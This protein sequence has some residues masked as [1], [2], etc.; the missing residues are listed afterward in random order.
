MPT[1]IVKLRNLTSRSWGNQEEVEAASPLEA[2]QKAS[3][4]T[5][6]EGSGKREW[7]RA[8]VWALPFDTSSSMN[9]YLDEALVY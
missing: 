3:N 8:K 7:L 1:Y 5:L 9:F 6:R 4:E 2:A